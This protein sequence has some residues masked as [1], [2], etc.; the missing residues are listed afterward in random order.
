MRQMYE[1]AHDLTSSFPSGVRNQLRACD[2]TAIHLE[3]LGKSLHGVLG[4]RQDP[5]GGGRYV[6]V[7]FLNRNDTL[8][9]WVHSV[10]HELGHAFQE[11]DGFSD[12][13]LSSFC[14]KYG[15]VV[16]TRARLREYLKGDGG[17]TKEAFHFYFEMKSKADEVF[18]EI[19]SSIWLARPGVRSELEGI[20]SAL[21]KENSV[22]PL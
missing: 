12:E 11:D 13:L 3:D 10:G 21:S 20:L 6:H 7:I 9:D 22:V 14:H 15:I 8:S 16:E 19:F 17:C 18:C 5:S 1:I 4:H 2:I